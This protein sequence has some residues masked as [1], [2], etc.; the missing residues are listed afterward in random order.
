MTNRF[1]QLRTAFLCAMPIALAS[2]PLR[3][4]ESGV[5]LCPIRLLF[6]VPCPGCGMTHAFA[7]LMHLDWHSAM[8]YNPRVAIVFP[9]I[10]WAAGRA[11][12]DDVRNLFG[13]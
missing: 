8:T 2:T 9:L 6:G 5:T 3:A 11:V 4:I 13:K 1:R 7:A 12:L 10:A